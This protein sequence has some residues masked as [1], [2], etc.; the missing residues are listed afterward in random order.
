[1][2]SFYFVTGLANIVT[3]LIAGIL[4]DVSPEMMF[5]YIA[6]MTLISI[7]MLGFVRE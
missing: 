4:W 1:M 5:A 2:G 3:G 7:V 6:I